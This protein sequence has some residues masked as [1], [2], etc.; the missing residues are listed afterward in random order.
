MTED[1]KFA[2]DTGGR[3][4]SCLAR[5]AAGEAGARDELIVF[6]IDRMRVIAHR[7]LRRFPNVRRWEET[8]DVVQNA[9]LRLY[10]TLS[11]LVPNDARAFTGLV[12][13][14]IRRELIDLARKHAG[15]RS[16]AANHETNVRQVDGEEQIKINDALGPA[17]SLDHLDRWTRM[18]EA[19]ASLPEEERELFNLAWYMGLKQEDISMLLGCSLRTV[20]RR[21][22]SAKQL[23]NNAVHGEPPQE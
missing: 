23:L 17:D 15:P 5:L 13:T 7:M 16:F 3:L 1:W 12:A 14:H 21:W 22:E 4:E 20:K 18:H 10:R 11:Q 6:A 2:D 8:D 19:A 9:S